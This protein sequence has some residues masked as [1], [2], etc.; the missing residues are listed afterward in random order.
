MVLDRIERGT[1][2]DTDAALILRVCGN[3]SGQALCALADAA[4]GPV[5]SLIANFG[6]EVEQHLRHGGCPLPA[7]PVF[8]NGGQS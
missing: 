2:S 3:M 4:I 7:Q 6:D 1:A 8:A 5:R